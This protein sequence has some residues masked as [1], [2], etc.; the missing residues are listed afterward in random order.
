MFCEMFDSTKASIAN[1][2]T[3]LYKGHFLI[4]EGGKVKVHPQLV[5]NFENDISIRLNLIHG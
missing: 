4:K 2:I 3:D 1:S 5:L